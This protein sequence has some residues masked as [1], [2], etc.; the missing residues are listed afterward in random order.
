MLWL[1]SGYKK[2]CSCA[3]C[4]KQKSELKMWFLIHGFKNVSILYPESSKNRYL[5]TSIFPVQ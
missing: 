3:K 5:Y 2:Q 1:A 4:K